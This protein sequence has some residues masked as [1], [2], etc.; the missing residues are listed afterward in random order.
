MLRGYRHKEIYSITKIKT[1]YSQ[2]SKYVAIPNSSI[3]DLPHND[4][5]FVFIYDSDRVR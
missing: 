2:E 4:F 3:L 5:Y 1:R